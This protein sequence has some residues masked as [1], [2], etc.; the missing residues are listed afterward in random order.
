MSF[1]HMLK[2]SGEPGQHGLTPACVENGCGSR[3]PVHYRRCVLVQIP[4]QLHGC[5]VTAYS[6]M[7]AHS[8]GLSA[9][10]MPRRQLGQAGHTVQCI[11]CSC[12]H[13][14]AILYVQQ[15]AVHRVVDKVRQ[16]PGT[17]VGADVKQCSGSGLG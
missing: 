12:R 6:R 3:C 11:A 9:Q 17:H 13:S 10:A 16:T 4:E 5:R 7:V 1:D 14:E 15:D 2:S 8:V